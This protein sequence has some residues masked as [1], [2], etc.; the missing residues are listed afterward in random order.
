[1]LPGYLSEFDKVFHDSTVKIARCRMILR[2]Q[3]IIDLGTPQVVVRS[4]YITPTW[5]SHTRHDKIYYTELMDK[6]GWTFTSPSF[7][8]INRILCQIRSDPKGGLRDEEGK[9]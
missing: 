1:M 3:N 9:F 4:E 6:N 8:F 5:I 7:Y 2:A